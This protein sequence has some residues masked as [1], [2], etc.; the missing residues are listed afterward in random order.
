MADRVNPRRS[1]IGRFH[2]LLNN[3]RCYAFDHWIPGIFR[4]CV[5]VLLPRFSADWKQKSWKTGTNR[6]VKMKLI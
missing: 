5:R 1:F 4:P 6:Q 3:W 2:D